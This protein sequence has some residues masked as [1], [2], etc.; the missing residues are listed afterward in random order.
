VD[1]GTGSAR[2]RVFDAAGAMLS[3]AK[4]DFTLHLASG[5]IA[6]QS[7]IFEC[8]AYSG[9]PAANTHKATLLAVR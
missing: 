4:Q 9:A 6:E 5:D 2:D 3:A 7:N 8:S 1:V